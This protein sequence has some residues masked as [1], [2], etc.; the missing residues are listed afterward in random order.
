MKMDTPQCIEKAR[1]Q[2]SKHS[3]FWKWKNNLLPLFFLFL[4]MNKYISFLHKA[5]T[6]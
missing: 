1:V 6:Q 5:Q 4:N 3:Y 2:K